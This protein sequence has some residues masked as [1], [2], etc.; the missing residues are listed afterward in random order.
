MSK[1]RFI[2]LTRYLFCL[3]AWLIIL[4]AMGVTAFA[5]TWEVKYEAD[6]LPTKSTPPWGGNEKFAEIKPKGVLHIND[7]SSAGGDLALITRPHDPKDMEVATI[8]IRVKS[9][10]NSD[11]WAVHV[12]IEDTVW[13]AVLFIFPDHIEL[14]N[15]QNSVVKVDMTDFHV[16]RVAKNEDEV[17]VF[18][19]NFGKGQEALKTK[20]A[21]RACPECKRVLFG[22]GS[23]AGQGESFWDYVRY[24]T[25]GAFSEFEES[26]AAVNLNGKL[27]TTWAS[28]KAQ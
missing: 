8:E 13:S 12:G 27:T 18:I 14:W 1:W 16:L 4:L 24:T 7:T 5:F 28:I 2:R 25:E 10:S 19:D 26:D 23:S 17:L 20:A 22:A 21:S 6:K 15:V 3:F 9:L 11:G